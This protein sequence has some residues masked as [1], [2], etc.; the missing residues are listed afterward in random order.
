MKIWERVWQTFRSL[1]QKM[2]WLYAAVVLIVLILF[3][4]FVGIQYFFVAVVVGVFLYFVRQ[5]ETESIPFPR[6]IKKA[7][8][9]FNDLKKKFDVIEQHVQNHDEDLEAKLQLV[10]LKEKMDYLQQKFNI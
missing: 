4:I 1:G 3:G 7:A 8:A 2:R 9:E 6:D 10:E 5:S